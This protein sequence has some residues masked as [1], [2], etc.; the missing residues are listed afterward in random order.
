MKKPRIVVFAYNL[1]VREAETDRFLETAGPIA[2][3]ASLQ[4]Q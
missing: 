4:V 3:P 1:S 2:Y